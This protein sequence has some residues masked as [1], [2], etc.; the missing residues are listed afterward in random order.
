MNKIPVAGDANEAIARYNV[1]LAS[2]RLQLIGQNQPCP[3]DTMS[4]NVTRS[5]GASVSFFHW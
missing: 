4:L 1:A 2:F 3:S 5:M